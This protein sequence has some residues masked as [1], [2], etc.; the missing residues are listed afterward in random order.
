M[1]SYSPD[2]KSI[3]FETSAGAVGPGLPDVFEMNADGTGLR[4]ITHTRN[5]ETQADWGS[6]G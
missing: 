2:G 3:V 6:A 5:F 4:Q 1:G